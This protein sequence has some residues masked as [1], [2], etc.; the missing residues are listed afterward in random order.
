M[1]SVTTV[2]RAALVASLAVAAACASRPPLP[3]PLAAGWNGVAVCERLHEDAEQRILRCTFPPAVGHERHFH[4]RHFGYAIA[5]GRMRI[6]DASGTRE[7][8]LA[9]GSSFTS[10]GVAWHEILNIGDS[11]VVYLIVEPKR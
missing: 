9:T 7:V 3:D 8:E 2:G 4:A 11:T 6:T 1:G 5:G 10:A